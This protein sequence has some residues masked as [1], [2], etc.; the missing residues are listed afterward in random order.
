MWNPPIELSGAEQRIE[1]RTGKTRKFFSFLRQVRHQLLDVELQGALAKTCSAEG[2]GKAPVEPGLMALATLLQAYSGVSDREAV[3]LT[4]MDRR[5]QMVLD[6]MD[7]E[8][9][10]FSQGTLFNFRQRLIE[11]EL[12]K[13]LLDK[14]VELAE[15]SGGFG[16][17]QLRA[18][19]DSSPLWGA[20]RVED[21][22]NLLGHALLKAVDIAAK[23]LGKTREALLE[24]AGLTLV[25]RSSLKAALDLDWSRA[26]SKQQA[27]SLVLAEIERWKSWLE[28]HSRLALSEPPMKEAMQTLDALVE[29]D[30][31]P[32]PR[33]GPGGGKRRIK[34]EV[35]R[36]RRVS[37][38][39][40]EMR[41]GRKSQSKRFNGFKQHF[42]VDLDSHVTREVAVRPANEAEHEAV[43][44]LREELERG[45]GLGQLNIDL[46]YM[47]SEHIQ[48]WAAEGVPI[49]ARPW[50]QTGEL[51]T[52]EHFKLD[53]QAM[54]ISCPG[55][56]STSLAPGRDAQF[57]A[58]ACDGCALRDRCTKAK[59][60]QGR[61]VTI[62]L[63]EQ[64]QQKLR[65]KVR[66]K[67]GRAQL[68]KR[69]VVE[70]RISH[71]VALQGRRARYKGLRKNQ[72]DGRRHA[73]VSNLQLA[74]SYEEQRAVA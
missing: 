70:H 34:K 47:G 23:E 67:R 16:A 41:H 21:T 46:G 69:V 56:Q 30:T 65:A 44:E 13:V 63:D 19:L 33:G 48:R 31:E 7:A 40:P 71:H 6:C 74:A 50:P 1:A 60:G 22:F 32:D 62:R 4:V 5:W 3:E 28:Q 20:A 18:A 72:F 43:E 36:D 53:F 59:P 66:T 27:L 57:P 8:K 17:R 26:E 55:G 11:G 29:Q 24:G 25:G 73:A 14:T 54:T 10:P 9:P 38:E 37:V 35:A 15:K 39:D 61:S 49:I 45:R 68:R 64:F 42:V 12:D 51:F 52:K 58:S 2:S